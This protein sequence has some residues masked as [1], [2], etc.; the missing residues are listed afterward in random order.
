MAL[1]WIDGFEN[2]GTTLANRPL[3]AGVFARKYGV[4]AYEDIRTLVQAGR[5][6]GYSMGH[7]W[8]DAGYFGQVGLTYNDTVVI[9]VAY[10]FTGLS[11]N[12]PIRLY[13]GT[14]MGISLYRDYEGELS[15]T[16]GTGTVLARTAGLNLSPRQWYYIEL[17]V[18][19]AASGTYE[20]HVGGNTYLSGSGNTKVGTH[21]YHDGFRLTGGAAYGR[22][23]DLYFL[24]ASG[25]ANNDFL[26][27]VCVVTCRADAAGD[28]TDWTPDSGDNYARINE[29]VCG[30]DTNYVQDDTTD[31]LDLYNY[32]APARLTGVHGIVVCDD[33]KEMDATAFN[34]KTVCKSASTTSAD[35]GQAIGT[36]N[37]TTRRRVME[38]DPDGPNDWNPTSLG[39]AQFGVQVG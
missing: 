4:V 25:T 1:L 17:K 37:Y 21:D 31:D 8:D 3:P 34:I 5:V 18:Q 10:Y 33:C 28:S 6:S 29:Q 7:G 24:D 39:A 35:A 9:G 36:T 22:F 38:Q 32:A 23:D 19:C 27:N 16:R 11:P 14:T 13:D 30:D 12:Y 2:Y 26:G 15:I 20:L